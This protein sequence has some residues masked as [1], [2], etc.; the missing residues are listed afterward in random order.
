MV[1]IG[2]DVDGVL[3]NCMG[4]F[5]PWYNQRH[6]TSFVEQDLWTHEWWTVLGVSKERFNQEITLFVASPAEYVMQPYQCMPAIVK[7][8]ATQHQL[9]QVTARFTP[10]SLAHAQAFS[11][12]HYSNCF[13]AI[14]R[15]HH[16]E[17]NPQG[18]KGVVCKREGV[19]VLVEDQT[20]YALEAFQHGIKVILIKRPWNV[21][22]SIPASI[23]RI[24]AKDLETTVAYMLNGAAH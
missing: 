9:S 15:S 2:F 19:A 18:Y 10:T 14:H 20:N 1:H 12:Y 5:L 21:Q 22:P 23:P 8:L 16:P 3:A 17:E 11:D 24:D 6:D 13:A 4:A 7:R